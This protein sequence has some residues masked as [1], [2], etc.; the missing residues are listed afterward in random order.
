MRR[1]LQ[2]RHGELYGLADI[3]RHSSDK[4]H[5]RSGLGRLTDELFVQ[6]AGLLRQTS[7]VGEALVPRSDAGAADLATSALPTADSTGTGN[8]GSAAVLY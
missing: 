2:V 4:R 7:R 3:P 8:T 1:E 5:G 6:G